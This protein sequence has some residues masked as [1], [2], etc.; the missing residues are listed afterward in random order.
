MKYA[1]S[2]MKMYPVLGIRILSYNKFQLRLKRGR[3]WRIKGQCRDIKRR[4][5]SIIRHAV[6][7]KHPQQPPRRSRALVDP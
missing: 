7:P 6:R 5:F 4:L 3:E 1:V 2:R